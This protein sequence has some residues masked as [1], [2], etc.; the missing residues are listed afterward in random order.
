MRTRRSLRWVWLGFGLCTACGNQG[1]LDFD[2]NVATQI[3]PTVTRLSPSVARAGDLVTIFGMGFSMVAADNFILVGTS[4]AVASSYALVSP[5]ATGELE[6]LTFTVPNAV[7]TGVTSL[8]VSVYDNVSNG[9]ILL[10]VT[11]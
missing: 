9:D 4:S 10:T 3:P 1:L 8:L 5:P 6:T 7:A 11:P 2:V